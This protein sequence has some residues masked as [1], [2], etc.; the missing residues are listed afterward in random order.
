MCGI[1]GFYGTGTDAV[2]KKMI[3]RINYRGPDH[4]QVSMSENVCLAHA[5]LSIIDL[6]DAA[7]QPMYNREKSL[8][9]IFN[10]EIYNYK[11]IKQELIRTGFDDFATNSDTE[12]LLMLY[13]K[14]GTEMLSHINGMFV[15]AI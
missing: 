15:F 4:R 5:R 2:G 6:S 11:A 14:Y 10:G 12:V 7:N 9:I 13:K 8:S 3:D 1:A